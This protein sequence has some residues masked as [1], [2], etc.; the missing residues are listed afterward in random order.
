M[1]E[2]VL[3]FYSTQLA[4]CVLSRLPSGL[5]KTEGGCSGRYKIGSGGF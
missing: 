2:R 3:S 5:R 1:L 4:F